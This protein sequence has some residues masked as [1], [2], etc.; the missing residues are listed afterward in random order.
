MGGAV[1]VGWVVENCGSAEGDSCGVTGC[2][3][4]SLVCS[5][6]L[7]T[8]PLKGIRVVRTFAVICLGRS[9]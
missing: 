4:P 1:C 9:G 8:L 2:W 3:R 5:D 6:C 7:W